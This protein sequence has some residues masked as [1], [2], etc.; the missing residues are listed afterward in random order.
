MCVTFADPTNKHVTSQQCC[1]CAQM[2]IQCA[3]SLLDLCIS[4]TLGIN[5]L[6][7]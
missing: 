6:L 7:Q 1:L 5:M 3:A 4:V 2:S